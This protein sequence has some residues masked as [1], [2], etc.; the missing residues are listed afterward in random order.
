MILVTGASGY[1]GSNMIVKLENNGYQV[2]GIDVN[3]TDHLTCKFYPLNMLDLRDLES[4][5]NDNNIDLVIH[6]AAYKS[7][8]ESVINPGKYYINNINILTNLLYCMQKY[9][10]NKLVFSSSATVYGTQPCP[11]N[12]SLSF[13]NTTNP[14]G[15]TKQ[16]CENII[17]D[18]CKYSDFRAISLRYFNPVG[19]ST[20]EENTLCP[21]EN[22][23]PNIL[24]AIYGKLTLQIFG[25]DYNTIDGTCERDFIHIDDLLDG[26]LRAIQYINL[27]TGYETF[28]LGTG[29]PCT[30][31]SLIN[32]FEQTFD[33][34]IPYELH[35]R[36]PG[37]IQT[38][39]CC[40]KKAREK[41]LWTPTKTIEDMCKSYIM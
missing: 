41:L 8:K 7:V 26:H 25:T 2:V 24:H 28:N 40:N 13:G 6:F 19:K 31:L 36:R 11:L 16:I 33:K 30:V 1:L 15:T 35:D 5:F 10:C 20:F 9:H 29:K 34:K 12:E 39:Y 21:A 3:H 27:N 22:L 37:D 17:K 14:Y 32:V 38:S 18:Y 23:V 4:V